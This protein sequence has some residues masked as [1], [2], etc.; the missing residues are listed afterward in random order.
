MTKPIALNKSD[1]NQTCI[2][3]L[4][5][6]SI[7]SSLRLEL[8]QINRVMWTIFEI[9]K[10]LHYHSSWA[11][12]VINRL[13]AYTLLHFGMKTINIFNQNQ[14]EQEEVQKMV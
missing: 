2:R 13:F 11:V 14:R 8:L 4:C 6:T 7:T 9:K 3:K 10:Q 12:K 5:T 1:V